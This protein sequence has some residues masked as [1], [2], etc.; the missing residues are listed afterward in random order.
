MANYVLITTQVSLSIKPE[1][2]RNP[3][4]VKAVFYSTSQ[5]IKLEEIEMIVPL[6]V[7]TDFA[8]T[9]S[10]VDTVNP[11]WEIRLSSGRYIRIGDKVMSTITGAADFKSVFFQTPLLKEEQ[12]K[13]GVVLV[14]LHTIAKGD[15]ADTASSVLR[16]DAIVRVDNYAKTV[17]DER[18]EESQS[19]YYYIFNAMGRFIMDAAAAPAFSIF[20]KPKDLPK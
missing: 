17:Y 15:K 6:E 13:D 19:E 16:I 10:D 9:F 14:P 3:R 7:P 18:G 12:Y 20:N 11:I 2:G 1:R 5:G 4:R 8:G